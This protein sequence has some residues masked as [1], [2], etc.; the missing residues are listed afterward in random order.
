MHLCVLRSYKMLWLWSVGFFC[1][2]V[3]IFIHACTSFQTVQGVYSFYTVSNSGLS[4][5]TFTVSPW[6]IWGLKEFPFENE[7]RHHL[8]SAGLFIWC[9]VHCLLFHLQLKWL[10]TYIIIA[11]PHLSFSED[12]NSDHCFFP[13]T[14]RTSI[15]VPMLLHRWEVFSL[16]GKSYVL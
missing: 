14:T 11:Q 6:F 1:V 2:C 3:L 9:S 16:S 12:W 5:Q 13:L 4:T 8:Y 10:H 15:S 7:Y